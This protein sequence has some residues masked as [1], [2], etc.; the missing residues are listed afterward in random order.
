MPGHVLNTLPTRGK[1]KY[2]K[3]KKTL[4]FSSSLP[5]SRSPS[6]HNK[7]KTFFLFLKEENGKYTY[8]I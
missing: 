3:K 1:K 6:N 4:L 2:Q 8:N 5:E 7:V